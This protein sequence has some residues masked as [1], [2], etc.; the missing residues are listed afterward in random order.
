MAAV[1]S[2]GSFAKLADHVGDLNILLQDILQDGVRQGYLPDV[3]VAQLARLIHRNAVCQR[4]TT[5]PNARRRDYRACPGLRR[6]GQV[7]C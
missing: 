7:C 6:R 4:R 5:Q 3:N 2:P 1:L